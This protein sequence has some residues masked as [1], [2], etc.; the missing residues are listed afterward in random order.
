MTAIEELV[1]LVLSATETFRKGEEV[2]DKQFGDVHI[3]EVFDMPH[4]D[5]ARTSTVDVHFMKI[6]F[7]EAAADSG[8]F[9]K[10]LREALRHDGTF[11]NLSVDDFLGGPSYI[12]VGAWI[13]SQDIALRL[14]ALGE[15]L[16]L[17]EVITPERLGITGPQVDAL[18]GAGF[19][20]FAPGPDLVNSL[21]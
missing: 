13:G 2:T 15:H 3:V 21:K 18:A 11:L 5:E 7:T 14:M 8:L 10:L 6:G 1:N 4:A 20:M 19:V 12:S 16:K 9:V 17:W